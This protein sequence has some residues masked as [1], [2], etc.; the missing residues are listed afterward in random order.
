MM[1]SGSGNLKKIKYEQE[2]LAIARG[3]WGTEIIL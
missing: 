3:C 2:A 1:K